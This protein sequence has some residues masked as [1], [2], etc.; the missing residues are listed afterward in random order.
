MS[1]KAVAQ[2]F[3]GCWL[4]ILRHNGKNIRNVMGYAIEKALEKLMIIAPACKDGYYYPG[5][6]LA[7]FPSE[8]MCKICI[9]KNKHDIQ[10]SCSR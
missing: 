6:E 10:M 4:I 9:I 3:L 7:E 2:T 8:E 1:T 5:Q